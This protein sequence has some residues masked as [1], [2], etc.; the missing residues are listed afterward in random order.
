MCVEHGEIVRLSSAAIL[1]EF[2]LQ[3]TYV[4]SVIAG[5]CMCSQ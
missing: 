5:H 3:L 2:V 4:P 1:Y